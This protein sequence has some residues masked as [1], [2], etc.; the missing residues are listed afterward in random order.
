MLVWNS[1]PLFL[2][3]RIA[4]VEHCTQPPFIFHSSDAQ[5]TQLS[6]E[7]PKASPE[8]QLFQLLIFLILH[9]AY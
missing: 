6:L 4:G 2:S 3:T 9:F 7:Q 8:G 1:L 5:R